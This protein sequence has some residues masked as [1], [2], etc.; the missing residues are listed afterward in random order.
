[1]GVTGRRLVF[2]GPLPLF[3][4]SVP[5]F[6]PLG[7]CRGAAWLVVLL[8]RRGLGELLDAI[9]ITLFDAGAALAAPATRVQKGGL[10]VV[11]LVMLRLAML[12][13]SLML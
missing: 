13:L 4:R 11:G 7:L 2:L 3:P 8:F 5:P 1:M 9:A 6:R 12:F 10:V